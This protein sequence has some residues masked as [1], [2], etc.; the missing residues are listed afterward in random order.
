MRYQD[1]HTPAPM[2][3]SLGHL[4]D[5]LWGEILLCEPDE[6]RHADE[7]RRE[8]Y[9]EVNGVVPRASRV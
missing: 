1:G 7:Q 2:V 6:G 5:S 4:F 8:S 3:T 9:H